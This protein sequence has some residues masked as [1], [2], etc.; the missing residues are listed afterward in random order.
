[1]IEFQDVVFHRGERAVLDGM[2]FAIEADERVAVLGESGSGKTTILKLAMGLLGPDSGKVLIDGEDI[3]QLRE[4]QMREVRM[5]FSIVFQEGALFDSLSVRENVAFYLR[6]YENYSENE[7]ERRVREMLRKVGVERAI[8]FM[9]EELSGGM[10]RRVAIARSL[11]AHEPRMFLYDEP[12]SDLDPLSSSTIL[13]LV[14][15]LS[16]GGRGFVMVTHEIADASKV[17]GRFLFIKEGRVLFD[18]AKKEFFH[19]TVPEVS[20]FVKESF[21]DI[22]Q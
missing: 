18:G 16:K 20:S 2:S 3:S 7:L 8:D 14:D 10:Q 13:R 6:E 11:A 17:S 9:P 1:M 21:A 4:E 22:E 5:K 15:D 19:S 12:T